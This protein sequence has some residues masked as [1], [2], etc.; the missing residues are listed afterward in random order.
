MRAAFGE[1]EWRHWQAEIRANRR[2]AATAP[3][4]QPNDDEQT[5]PAQPGP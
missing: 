1:E 2:A 5:S 3:E 4:E